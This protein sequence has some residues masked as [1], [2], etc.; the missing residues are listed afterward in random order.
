M[1]ETRL[2]SLNLSKRGEVVLWT[3]LCPLKIHVESLTPK[4]TIFGYRAFKEVIMVKRGH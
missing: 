1:A 3:E 4:V 2:L